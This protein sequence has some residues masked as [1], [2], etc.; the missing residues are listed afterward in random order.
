MQIYAGKYFEKYNLCNLCNDALN[1][2]KALKSFN[3]FDVLCVCVCVGGGYA[4]F[5]SIDSKAF[6]RQRQ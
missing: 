3:K 5:C 4:S 6:K 1:I 2:A